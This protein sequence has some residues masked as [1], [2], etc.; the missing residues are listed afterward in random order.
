ME[1]ERQLPLNYY[2]INCDF[3]NILGCLYVVSCLN[4]TLE[5]FKNERQIYINLEKI[6]DAEIIMKT[7]TECKDI[8]NFRDVYLINKFGKHLIDLVALPYNFDILNDKLTE[9]GYCENNYC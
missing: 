4:T 8:K 7:L 5:E 3:K 1:S 6:E 2:R 9:L